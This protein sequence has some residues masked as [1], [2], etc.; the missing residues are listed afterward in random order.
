MALGVGTG[1]ALAKTSKVPFAWFTCGE[2]LGSDKEQTHA[3]LFAL[4]SGTMNRSTDFLMFATTVMAA[5]SGFNSQV[6]ST[7]DAIGLMQVTLIGAREAEKQCI[8]PYPLVGDS[9]LKKRLLDPRA[10]AAYGTCLLS[11]HLRQTRGNQVLA[12]ILY[13]GG[14]QQLTRFLTTGTLHKETLEYV[15]RVQSYYGRCI[16]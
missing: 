15:L 4:G 1:N 2:K 8:L 12:L 14:S 3:A 13:N 11:Y 7:A 10:N 6:V 9:D 5:E 16:Q